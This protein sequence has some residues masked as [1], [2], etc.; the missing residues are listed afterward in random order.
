MIRIGDFARLSGVSVVTLRH[1][2][3]EGLLSPRFVDPDSGYRYFESDQLRH[4]HRILLLKELGLSLAQIREV[5]RDAVGIAGMRELLNA[6]RAE[7]QARIGAA[8][9]QIRKIEH[10]LSTIEREYTMPQLEVIRKT[11][12]PMTVA[13]IHLDI[14]TNDQVGDLL[15]QA[16][17]DLYEYLE[18]K[19]IAPKGPCL[20]VWQSSPQDF[21][22]ESV[23]AA[24]PI[25]PHTIDHPAIRVKTLPSQDVASVVHV[26]PF[27]DFQQGH[28]ALSE[29][30]T[31]NG[32][33]LNGDYREIYHTP[34][35][36]HATTE[37]LYPVAPE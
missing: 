17:C 27:S 10:H 21:T 14:A 1:Y 29:W 36:D 8:E 33:R 23:D 22:D 5:L 7:A 28:V 24:V 11:T 26:G 32:C 20:A 4:V 37:I 18:K 19:G 16:Y 3:E 35:G 9:A 13:Y 30:L 12:P 31:A 15:G 6:K 2:D 34:P 25:D